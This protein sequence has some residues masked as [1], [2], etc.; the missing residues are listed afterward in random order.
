MRALIAMMLAMMIVIIA[1][2][3]TMS[4]LD[5]VKPIDVEMSTTPL[6]T[7]SSSGAIATFYTLPS[8]RGDFMEA[9]NGDVF[10]F[11]SQTGG[12]KSWHI[13]SINAVPGQLMAIWSRSALGG[14]DLKRF[15]MIR[16]PIRDV[17]AF[18]SQY[19]DMVRGNTGIHLYGWEHQDIDFVIM[20]IDETQYRNLVVERKAECKKLTDVWEYSSVKSEAYCNYLDPVSL[21]I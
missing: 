7:V 4:R 5:P 18:L 20:P 9:A 17:E 14:D 11:C 10:L 16:H 15:F 8:L 13:Q 21:T 12:Q 3:Y 2:S 19:D 1:M 6:M